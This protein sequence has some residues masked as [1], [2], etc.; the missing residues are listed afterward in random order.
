MMDTN[1]LTAALDT[2]FQEISYFNGNLY[3]INSIMESRSAQI[4]TDFPVPQEL[5]QTG[6]YFRDVTLDPD[7]DNLF[8]TGYCYDVGTTTLASQS[9][10][11]VSFICCNTI[12]SVYESFDT[13]LKD[14]LAQV[15]FHTNHKTAFKLKES[16][17]T[18]VEIRANLW[19]VRSDKGFLK[20]IRRVAPTFPQFEKKNIYKHDLGNWYNMMDITRHQIVHSRQQAN[21]TFIVDLKKK[22]YWKLFC[23]NFSIG[24]GE[25]P[26]ILVTYG[27][28]SHILSNF[29]EYAYLIFKTLSHDLGL[30][31]EITLPTYKPV[32]NVF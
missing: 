32:R 4:K 11:S 1:F 31:Y 13:F 27:Q 5:W 28:A 22:G 2:F 15:Y 3:I 17:H 16:Y 9:A 14:M 18:L 12:A 30:P 26:L 23:E 6:T 8:P 7:A 21:D 29:T 25:S 24:T 19:Q 10:R 20:I